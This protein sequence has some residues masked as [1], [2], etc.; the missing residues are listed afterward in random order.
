M[1]IDVLETTYPDVKADVLILAA[2]EDEPLPPPVKYADER[3]NGV[4]AKANAKKH[5]TAE[6][7]QVK[8]FPLNTKPEYVILIGLGKKADW[9]LERLRRCAAVSAKAA[10]TCGATVATDIHRYG[11]DPQQAAKAATI[12]TVLGLY[13]FTRYKTVGLEKIKS[14]D[15][16]TLI[17]QDKQK[18][19]LSQG[20]SEGIIIAEAV[21]AARDIVNTPAADM[22]PKAL[23][24]EAKRLCKAVGCGVDI[25][26]RRGLEKKGM[27]A[28]LGVAKGSSAE[29]Q[30]VVIEYGP[31]KQKP[32]VL[33]GKGITFDTGGLS[34][35]TP[36]NLMADM[37]DDKGGA[38]AVIGTMTAI[39]RL[40]VQQRVIGLIPTC[41]NGIDGESQKP[42]D[43]VKTFGGKTIEILNTDAEGRLILADALGYAQSL[44]PQAIID[45]ATL[46]GACMVALGYANSGL[47]S[48]DDT[49]R[50]RLF[51]AGSATGDALWPLPMDKDYDDL[52]RSDIADV[53]NISKDGY[54]G[55]IVG[56]I[57]LQNF[58]DKVPYAH[59]DIA[60]PAFLQEEKEY[61]LKGASGAGVRVL[62]ETIQAWPAEK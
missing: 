33:V 19:L 45:V 56:A 18:A 3:L 34:L 37:K 9:S 24:Q 29:P 43:I 14:V 21:T 7:K 13:Q 57:F 58:V 16:V 5:W 44:Q 55:A 40:K 41:E 53:K 46:T 20:A 4:I 2:F 50:D 11:P 60:G 30:F 48:R 23:A 17:D 1:Q 32:I 54:A 39:A 27:H 36:W 8:S 42:G 38:A 47:F 31:K 10:R 25:W 61:N 28:I 49:L 22:T 26:D 62:V 12:G 59:L 51:Q 6:Y 52:V 15:H 35:K